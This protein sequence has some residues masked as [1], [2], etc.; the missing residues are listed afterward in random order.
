MRLYPDEVWQKPGLLQTGENRPQAF[1]EDV[2]GRDEASLWRLD[3]IVDGGD[4]GVV[5]LGGLLR[6]VEVAAL[7]WEKTRFPGV[8]GKTLVADRASGLVT[9][10]MKCN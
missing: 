10:L 3:R 2:L 6:F 4:V 5:E 9:A 1:A 7:P 8:E